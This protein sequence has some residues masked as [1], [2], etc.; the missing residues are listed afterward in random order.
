LHTQNV[1]RDEIDSAVGEIGGQ[2]EFCELGIFHIQ[3]DT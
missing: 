3:V 1:G 2:R